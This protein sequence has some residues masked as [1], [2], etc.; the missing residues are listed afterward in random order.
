[1]EQTNTRHRDRLTK[2]LIRRLD[3]YFG[4]EKK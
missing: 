3:N 2:D 4:G 1:M